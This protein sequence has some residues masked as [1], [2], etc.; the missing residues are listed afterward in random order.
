MR[1]QCWCECVPHLHE[2]SL[3]ARDSDFTGCFIV[4]FAHSGLL[5][6]GRPRAGVRCGVLKPRKGGGQ[7]R[8]PSEKWSADLHGNCHVDCFKVECVSTRTERAAQPRTRPSPR[9]TDGGGGR[10]AQQEGGEGLPQGD[11]SCLWAPVSGR[12]LFLISLFKLF[13]H[14]AVN[15][16]CL[17]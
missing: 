2:A 14:L 7:V 3:F 8:K 1:D 4:S 5:T 13:L 6:E 15:R 17:I 16:Y 10:A 11:R 9:R 12:F